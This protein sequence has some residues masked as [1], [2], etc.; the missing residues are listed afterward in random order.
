MSD[1]DA[2]SIAVLIGGLIATGALWG[3]FLWLVRKT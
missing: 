3:V 2:Q 1:W